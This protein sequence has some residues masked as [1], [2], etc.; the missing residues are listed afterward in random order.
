[1]I[2][3]CLFSFCISSLFSLIA[4]VSIETIVRAVTGW[5][6]F[7]PISPDFIALFPSDTIAL[8]VNVILYGVIG[9]AFAGMM[10]IYEIERIGFVLQSIIYYGAT[11]AVWLPIVTVLWQLQNY[12]TA[13]VCTVFAFIVTNVIMTIVAYRVTRKEVDKINDFLAQSRI[14]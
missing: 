7:N 2:K 6:Y 4:L 13:L 10:V 11:M 9:V 12:P 3:R 5:E 14:D 1:M 8:G